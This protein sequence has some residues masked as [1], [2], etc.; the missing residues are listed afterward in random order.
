MTIIPDYAQMP[1]YESSSRLVVPSRGSS[2]R[3]YALLHSQNEL[4]EDGQIYQPQI[5]KQSKLFLLFCLMPPSCKPQSVMHHQLHLSL[6]HISEPT[7]LGMISYAVF[8]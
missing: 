8:C 1:R 4:A 7:R 6:I 5:C 3:D 2:E